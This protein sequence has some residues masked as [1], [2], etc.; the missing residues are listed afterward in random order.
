MQ[1]TV[2]DILD[3]TIKNRSSRM[4]DDLA[5][6]SA[7]NLLFYGDSVPWSERSIWFKIKWHAELWLGRAGDAWAVLTGKASIGEDC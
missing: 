4:V 6:P 3:A 7:L 2:N 5:R 1:P